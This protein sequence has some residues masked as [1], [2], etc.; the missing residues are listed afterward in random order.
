MGGSRPAG[1]L[2]CRERHLALSPDHHYPSVTSTRYP[3]YAPP[4][5]RPM[6]LDVPYRSIPDMFRMRVAATP[7]GQAMAVPTADDTGLNWLTWAQVG[8]RAYAIAAG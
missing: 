4:R 5:R 6:A 8:E 3:R 7:N 1:R 2:N